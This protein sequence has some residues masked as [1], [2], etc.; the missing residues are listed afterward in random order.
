MADIVVEEV[1]LD[2]GGSAVVLQLEC[3]GG[4]LDCDLCDLP[5]DLLMGLL[6]L[7]DEGAAE[8]L[9]GVGE[10]LDNTGRGR[11]LLHYKPD[12]V[13]ERVVGLFVY[14]YVFELLAEGL[15]VSGVLL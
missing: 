10:Q 5:V 14:F 12:N 15:V 8:G 7:D 11:L 2:C 13:L 9:C 1:E 6:V 4:E 3:D